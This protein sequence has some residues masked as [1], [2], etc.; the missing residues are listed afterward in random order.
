M[1]LRGV[2]SLRDAEWY[3]DPSTVEH[4]LEIDEYSLCRFRPQKRLALVIV[5]GT[6][7]GFKHEIEFTWLGERAWFGSVG[8]EHRCEVVEFGE[9]YQVA[10]PVQLCFVLRTQFKILEG[11]S[12]QFVL[13]TR[14]DGHEQA[15]SFGFRPTPC[16]LV[17]AITSF[18]LATVG[19]K[20]MKQI[21]MS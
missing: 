3:P 6:R 14:L 15:F 20:I 9:G 18:R 7:M 19:H 10:G 8:T 1:K 13:V 11:T 16:E 17:E 5:N 21:V 4:I 12:F 2:I